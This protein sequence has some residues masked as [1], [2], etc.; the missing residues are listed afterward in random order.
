MEFGGDGRCE[1]KRKGKRE[2]S[3]DLGEKRRR[4]VYVCKKRMK[5]I[6]KKSG[7]KGEKRL[8][9]DK[10]LFEYFLANIYQLSKI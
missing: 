4:G 8:K 1:K 10:L 9:Y 7:L 6:E 3:E 2:K 5:E